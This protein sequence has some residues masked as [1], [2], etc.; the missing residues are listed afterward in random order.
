V[1]LIANGVN[2]GPKAGF[3]VIGS[4]VAFAIVLVAIQ[5]ARR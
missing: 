4:M 5:R 2:A 3:I 1:S